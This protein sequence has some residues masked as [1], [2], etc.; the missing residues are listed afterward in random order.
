[1]SRPKISEQDKRIVQ[2][3]IRLTRGENETVN[4]YAT[5]SGLS[6]ANWIREKLF[7]GKA[8]SAKL[9]ALD[10][11]VYQEL[12]KIGVNLNQATHKLNQ[13]DFPKE[14]RTIQFEL[15]ILLNHIL[16]AIVHDRQHDQG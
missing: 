11:S 14:L 5:A 12:R 3:N 4:E 7:T 10:A 2:V 1:M 9:S 6:P 8:P 15:M 16:K 13:G